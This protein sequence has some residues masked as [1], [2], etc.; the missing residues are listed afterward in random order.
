MS[1]RIKL[2][3]LWAG[4]AWACSLA[5]S[6]VPSWKLVEAKLFDL[7][8][9]AAAPH[10]SLL[11]I[12]IVRIDEASFAQIGDQWPWP[13]GLHA[14]LLDN[15]MEAGAAVVAFDIMFP[16]AS[17]PEQDKALAEAI[18]NTFGAVVLA[19]DHAYHETAMTRQ[20]IRV[21]PLPLFNLAGAATG[22]ATINLDGDGVIR[23]FPLQP[24]AFWRQVIRTLISMQPGIVEEPAVPEGA[25]IRHLGPSHTFPMI[26]YY[27]V[28]N[29]DASIPPDF[30]KDQIVLVGR[31]VRSGVE[32]GSAQAD[33]FATPFLLS[34]GLLT[35]GVEIHATLIENALMGQAV[36]PIER[37]WTLLTFSLVILL[38]LPL[39][40]WFHVLRSAL[41]V[42]VLMLAAAYLSYWRLS[43]ANIWIDLS[44]SLTSL[45]IMYL[46]VGI[47]SYVSERQR[48]QVIKLAFSKYV[49][50]QVVEKMIDNKD[51]LKVGGEK[52]ELTLLFSDIA[53][54]T[55]LSERLSPEQIA[56]VMNLYL[57][58]M[59]RV[60]HRHG[61]TLDKFIG[62][63]VMAFWG[64]P[65]DDPEHAKHGALA[66]MDMQKSLL[67]LQDRLAE[68]GAA[69]LKMRVGVHTGDAIVGN[70]GSE[71]RFDY[72]ALGDT[73]N[74][75]SRLEGVNKHYG[76]PVLLSEATAKR[77]DGALGIRPVDW[78]K[79]KG[80]QKAIKIYTPCDDLSLT[81]MT[82]QALN[83]YL[84]QHWSE[85][86]AQ[87]RKIQQ[88]YPEDPLPKVFIPRIQ[89]LQQAPPEDWDGAT[90]LEK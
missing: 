31:D 10:K 63:A 12:T 5:L 13:R 22:L 40:I 78:V 48:S 44:Y 33:M 70:M 88:D 38:A 54:F 74:L 14:Q 41:L 43:E 47:S 26:S 60:V 28:L 81:E 2:A 39:I 80:K 20:W 69:G 85:A 25:W 73:V 77:L 49:S 46:G 1:N 34:S 19:A 64:A 76:T 16:E 67:G 59:T 4:I 53:G 8:T 50:A 86:E 79:V 9:L 29:G 58:E 89:R 3:L 35:S 37:P 90:P 65:L 71:D 6:Y 57:T 15:L 55:S 45:I 36:L 11:P 24:D 72:T 66:A 7:A 27:Q 32:T 83:A 82:Y 52:K 51:N 75:A 62:D 23:Q 56:E 17:E 68:M 61:G 21:D 30:F 87:W 18:E 84:S 42:L